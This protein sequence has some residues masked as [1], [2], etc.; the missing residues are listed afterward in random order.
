[1][2]NIT[3]EE[4]LGIKGEGLENAFIWDWYPKRLVVAIEPN[5][6]PLTQRQLEKIADLVGELKDKILEHYP[7]KDWL[8]VEI[9][10]GM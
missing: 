5:Q 9:M 4:L 1:M 10:G 6:Y 8:E 2:S 7:D 3:V